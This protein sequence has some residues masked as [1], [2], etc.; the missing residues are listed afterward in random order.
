MATIRSEWKAANR[1]VWPR[2]LSVIEAPEGAQVEVT[3]NGGAARSSAGRRWSTPRGKP[4]SGSSS[5][6]AAAEDHDRRPHHL[7]EHDRARRPLPDQ[8]HR[9][10]EDAAPVPAA[11]REDRA[12]LRVVRPMVSVVPVAR[13]GPPIGRV[14]Y[15]I[16]RST[17]TS[18]AHASDDSLLRVAQSGRAGPPPSRAGSADR[19]R[20]AQGGDGSPRRDH[21]RRPPRRRRALR[22][23]RG[24]GP[25]RLDVLRRPARAARRAPRARL[26]RARR[27]SPRPATRTST[28]CATALGLRARRARAR[29]ARSR[30]PRPSASATATRRPAVR[31]GDVDRRRARASS[32]GVLARRDARR[33]PSRVVAQPARRA[34]AARARATGRACGARS[35]AD[36]R[37]AARGGQGRRRPR[38]RRRRLPRRARSGSSPRGA[39]GERKFIVANGDE[40]D[41]GSYID[42]VLMED[43][44]HL[45]LEGMALAGYAVGADH[46][47]VLVRSRVPALQAARSTRR[48]RGARDGCSARHPRRDFALRRHDRRGRRLLRRRRGDRAAR[49]ACRACAAPSPRGRR[50]PPS[51]ACTACRRSSTTS[52]RCATSR[53]SPRTAPTPTARSARSAT[54]GTKLVCFNERFARPGVYEVPF[55]MTMRELC[56]DV[57]GGLRDGRAIKALQIGGP[58]GGILP[59]LACSTRAFDFDAARRRGLHG[60]PRRDR[61]LRRH[62]RHARASPSTCCTSAPPRAAASASRAGSGC[63]AR[64][65]CS[66]TARRSTASGWRRCSRRSSSASLCAHGG[67]MPAPIRSLLAHFPEELG[68]AVITLDDRRHGRSRSRPARPCSRPRARPAASP[69]AVLRRAPGAVRRVPRVPGR[70]RGRARAGR[71]RARRRAATAW[72]ST[73][74]DADR[75]PR[76]RPRVV[77]LV[78]SELPERARRAHRARRRSRAML[79]VGEPRWPGEQHARRARRAPSVPRASST[80]CA[81]PAGAACARATRSRAT[82]ALTA[83][84]RGFD[85]NIAAGLDEGFRESAC[86]VVRRVRRHVPDRRD[87]RDLPA[88]TWRGEPCPSASTRRHHHLRLLRRRLPPGGARARRRDRLDQPGARR[89]R[90]RGPHVPEGPLRAPVLAPPRPPAPRR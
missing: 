32:S 9:R 18:A 43:N 13:S 27:A 65:R 89:P 35:R 78:L 34:G 23:A 85:A 10:P 29:T 82:F 68:L 61:R 6:A 12:A 25:R 46:G 42:K 16:A 28:R 64:T 83:T 33:R 74:S 1:R 22:P 38:P 51:A 7:P 69:D 80:S 48:S 44:P 79:D 87:H 58:L 30:S 73:R 52:R 71:R 36:A 70:R 47:F 17:W 86:V 54:P 26:H 67:G 15:N 11:G 90:Q 66:P 88:D 24:R 75:A 39:P 60:R 55:G 49:A 62:D 40:G 5:S 2:M 50:S 4:T 53:S 81:S 41:P 57:A 59:A 21:R 19:A 8:D 84:G 76:R 77:E 37:G 72:R 14:Y 56:E 31:D 45:L 20:G 3:C 63:A